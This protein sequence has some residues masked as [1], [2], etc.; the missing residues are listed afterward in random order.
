VAALLP[1]VAVETAKEI[2]GVVIPCP[3]DIKGK[4]TKPF[5][6]CREFGDYRKCVNWFHGW[7]RLLDDEVL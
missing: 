3:P 6:R 4:I 5:E 2:D 1:K 7:H